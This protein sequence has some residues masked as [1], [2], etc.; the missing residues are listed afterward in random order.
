M[1]NGTVKDER[2]FNFSAGPCMLPV[3]VLQECQDHMM[4]WN[5]SGMGVME[6]SHRGKEFVSIYNQTVSDLRDILQV[7]DSHSLFFMQGGATTQFASV[8]LNLLKEPSNA[9][10]YAVTG[11]WGDKAFKECQ[12]YGK[13]NKVCDTK[14]SNYTFIPPVS[15]WKVNPEASYLHYCANETIYGVEFKSTPDVGLPLVSDMSSNFCSKPIEVSKHTLIY[16]GIQKN[17]G[18]AGAAVVIA[19]KACLGNA[20]SICPTL[21]DYKTMSDSESMYNTPPCWSIYV[22]GLMAKYLKEK[23]GLAFWKEWSEKKAKILYD[24][25]DGS[26]GYFICPTAKDCRSNMNIPFRVGRGDEA[27]EKKFLEEGKKHKLVTLSGHR[28]VG[29]CRASLYNGMPIEGVETLVSFM[30][31]FQEANP[32]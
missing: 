15:E 20:K 14:S 6:M 17:L 10:D 16:A 8:P 7:P 4:N 25:I 18:P 29:G 19:D 9:A 13:A 3:E 5:G 27:L 2:L 1:Q 28:T 26:D 22:V 21:L 23:G 31:E 11:S 30:R 12:K 32:E 24:A